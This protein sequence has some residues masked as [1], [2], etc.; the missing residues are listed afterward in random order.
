MQRHVLILEFA[1]VECVKKILSRSMLVRA[2]VELF[3]A[4]DTYDELFDD[5]EKKKSF[6]EVLFAI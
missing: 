3:S 5:L 2:A 6:F 1:D 4:R